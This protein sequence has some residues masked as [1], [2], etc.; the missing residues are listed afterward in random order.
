MKFPLPMVG[1]LPSL[2]SPLL[3]LCSS[4]S[5]LFVV[6]LIDPLQKEAETSPSYE[7]HREWQGV[8]CTKGGR[9]I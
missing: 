6:D 4:L 7:Y 3:S 9:V 8:Q 5:R 1:R 2:E